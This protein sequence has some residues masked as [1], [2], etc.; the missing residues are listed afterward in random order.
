MSPATDLDGLSKTDL[1]ALII[2]LLGRVAELERTRAAKRDEIARLKGLKARP[3]IKPS[4]MEQATEPATPARRKR[5]RGTGRTTRGRVIH[6]ER[7][8]RAAVPSGSRFK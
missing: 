2:E 8:V 5:R 7:I 1:K 4:G 6:E 3:E